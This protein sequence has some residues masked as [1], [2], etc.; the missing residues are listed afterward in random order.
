MIRK[1]LHRRAMIRGMGSVAIALPLLD[2][3]IPESLIGS[4]A[5]AEKKAKVMPKNRLSVLYYPNGLHTPAWYPKAE[6]TNYEMAGLLIEPLQRHRKDFI[7]MGGLSV[8]I[9]LYDSA[10]DHAKAIG[11]YLTGVRIRKT[12]ADDIQCAISMDQV[13]ANK[14]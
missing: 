6:G 5:A 3:M 13:V 9:A 4:A 8:P 7:L 11:C 1:P 2:A 14:I 10:G 12:A